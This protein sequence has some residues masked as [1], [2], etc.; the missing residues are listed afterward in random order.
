MIEL[1]RWNAGKIDEKS[2]FIHVAQGRQQ[3]RK[4]SNEQC[5]V[6][7][8]NWANGANLWNQDHSDWIRN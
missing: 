1:W 2:D 7:E 6:R 4:A 5:A 8:K 3:S